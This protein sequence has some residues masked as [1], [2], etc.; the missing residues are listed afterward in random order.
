MKLQ[1]NGAKENNGDRNR[2][3]MPHNND[4]FLHAIYLLRFLKTL[5]DILCCIFVISM[6]YSLFALQ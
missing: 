1:N 6:E 5:E 4:V 3:N 2:S